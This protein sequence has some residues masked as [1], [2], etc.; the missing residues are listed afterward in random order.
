MNKKIKSALKKN[1]FV[2]K[3]IEYRNYKNREKSVRLL[4]QDGTDRYQKKELKF[5]NQP[6]V[7]IIIL[8]RDGVDKLKDLMKSFQKS[9]FYKNFEIVFVDNASTD[10]SVDYMKEWKSTYDI[11]IICNG[12]NRS[13][14][15]ANNQGARVAKGEYLLFL[16]N[17]VAVTDGWLDELLAGALAT[18]NPGAI[19]AR[20]IYPKVLG[21]KQ[22]KEKAYAVQHRGIAF[23]DT[24]RKKE[25]FIRP[26]NMG[27]G[28]MVKCSDVQIT[29]RVAVMAAAFMVSRSAFE[30]VGGFSEEYN[31]GFEDVDFCL[32]LHRKGYRNYYCPLSVIYHYEFGTRDKGESLEAKQ[33]GDHNVAVFQGKWQKYLAKQILLDKLEGKRLFTESP[34]QIAIACSKEKKTTEVLAL[35]NRFKQKGYKVLYL[36]PNDERKYYSVTPASDVLIV[37]DQAYFV[38]NITNYK[39]DLMVVKVQDNPVAMDDGYCVTMEQLLS[40]ENWLEQRLE[41]LTV[42]EV[43]GNEIDICGCMPNDHNMK[44]WGDLYF[45]QAMKEEFEKRG[46]RANVRTRMDWHKKSTAKYTIFL[47]GNREYYPSVEE[48][49]VNIMWNISHPEET[50]LME[51]NSFDYVFFASD[52]LKEQMASLSV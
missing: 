33:R 51:Y 6:L 11:Q 24:M 43:H 23:K 5:E 36:N 26:Y 7:S 1:P 9:D 28:E 41:T 37:L 10:V 42:D 4:L 27:N 46:Y 52:K 50:S 48:G 49:R 21:N 14:S 22:V 12:E 13:F 34:L 35:E 31:Y 40:D 17:D 38:D 15:A 44:F 32:K 20:L 45:A 47:R 16:N 25:Y 8:N 3:C 19:G 2:K 29:E 18:D 30:A 39:S